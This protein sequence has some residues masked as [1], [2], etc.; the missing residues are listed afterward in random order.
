MAK[1]FSLFLGKSVLI[2]LHPPNGILPQI[3]CLSQKAIKAVVLHLLGTT[4]SRPSPT[5]LS[6][7]TRAPA[8]LLITAWV[9]V[10]GLAVLILTPLLSPVLYWSEE[11]LGQ[12]NAVSGFSGAF[13]AWRVGEKETLRCAVLASLRGWQGDLMT[14]TPGDRGQSGTVWPWAAYSEVMDGLR[15]AEG[16]RQE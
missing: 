10:S 12:I 11:G 6:T 13:T 9:P 16:E 4:L 3:Y 1:S 5:L 7:N 8:S 14:L 15:A 2:H